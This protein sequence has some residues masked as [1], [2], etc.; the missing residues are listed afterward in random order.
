MSDKTIIY[1]Y[2]KANQYMGLATSDK[3]GKPEVATVKYVLDGD[4]LLLNTFV[5][6]R[7]YRN[8]VDN[9]VV[10]CVVTTGHERTLQFEGTVEELK[11]SAAEDAKTK[12]LAVDPEFGKFFINE[13]TRFFRIT[14]DWMRLRDYTV[15][16]MLVTE[17]KP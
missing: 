13:D 15:T 12:M 4:S 5:H 7:K 2:L 3:H 8:L 9:P 14:P 16:P 11:G 1:D 10:A 6:Y 17:Y